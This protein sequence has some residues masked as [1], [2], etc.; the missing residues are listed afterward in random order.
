TEELDVYK[1]PGTTTLRSVLKYPVR[2]SQANSSQV[3]FESQND[4]EKQSD[5]SLLPPKKKRKTLTFARLLT[6]E[7]SWRQLKEASE[8]AERKIAETKR[9]KEIT[10]QKKAARELDLAQKKEECAR[11]I[12]QIMPSYFVLDLFIYV[13]LLAV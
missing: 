1:N 5:S 12:L 10:A 11:K 3:T 4:P 6:N 13:V 8:E 7:E 2:N 9:K